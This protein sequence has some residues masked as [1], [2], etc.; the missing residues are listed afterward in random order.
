MH[1]VREKISAFV[2]SCNR[3]AIIGT[4]LRALRFADEV[5]VVDKS[6]TDDTPSIAALHADRV[7]TVPWSPTVEHTRAFA[8][9]QCTHDWIVFVDD[10]ECLSPAA[11]AFIQA[12]L[13]AP[14]ADIYRLPRRDYILGTH[15]ERAYYWPEHHIR[16]FR[17]GAVEFSATVHGGIIPHADQVLTVAAET[18]VCIH[19]LSHQDVAQW[20]EKTNRY[21]SSV[22]RT[23]VEHAGADLIDFAH[24]RIDHW[25]GRTRDT[26][27]DGYP[28]AVALLRATYDLI[29]RLKVWEEERGRD[30]AALFDQVCADLDAAHD[31]T[32]PARTGARSTATPPVNAAP[33]TEAMLRA[34][35]RDLRAHHE[36]RQRKLAQEL[37]EA[38]AALRAIENSTFWRAT[39]W[40]RRVAGRLRAKPITLCSSS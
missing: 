33:D 21:T 23:R 22:D 30:G 7:I 28:A 39:A 19:H 9:T 4:C 16:L 34:N 40:P 6:S 14:R 20:V 25:I 13:A 1:A 11:A 31:G 37:A 3:A 38:R 32:L 8:V 17:R 15:D 10:D 5:I 27:P 2:V 18:G 29:D 36:T 24:A 26:T 35:L 12:E